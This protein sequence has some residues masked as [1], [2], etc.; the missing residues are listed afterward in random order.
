MIVI[1]C[2][3]VVHGGYTHMDQNLPTCHSWW[4]IG[5]RRRPFGRAHSTAHS[6]LTHK[7]GLQST[8]LHRLNNEEC[9][10]THTHTP[11][12]HAHTFE[13]IL[14][15]NIATAVVVCWMPQLMG[16]KWTDQLSNHPSSASHPN[17]CT[18]LLLLLSLTLMLPSCEWEYQ[19]KVLAG[20]DASITNC[21]LN[22]FVAGKWGFVQETNERT[23]ERKREEQ[24]GGKERKRDLFHLVA[25]RHRAS[26]GD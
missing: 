1:Y 19:H 2:S 21:F 20:E 11:H 18:S 10:R 12:T 4:L 25:S 15:T 16:S 7:T 3:D 8:R 22:W 24:E 6:V 14:A 13:W 17:E 23:N 26:F 5:W 9:V